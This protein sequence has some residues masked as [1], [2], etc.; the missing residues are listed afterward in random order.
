MT[1]YKRAVVDQHILAQLTFFT[2]DKEEPE[3][4]EEDGC[5]GAAV[6]NSYE[7]ITPAQGHI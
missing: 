5:T 7:K 2:D 3:N 6:G 4:Q 1:K